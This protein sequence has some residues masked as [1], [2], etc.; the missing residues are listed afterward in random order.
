MSDQQCPKCHSIRTVKDQH[1]LKGICPSCGIAYDK[2]KKNKSQNQTEFRADNAPLTQ[3]DKPLHRLKNTLLFVPE[4]ID[5]LV[6][7]SRVIIYFIFF[8]WGWKFILSGSGWQAIMGSFM[9]NINLPFHEFG[10]VLF[11]PFG[12]FMTLYP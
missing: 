7:R 2:W 8:I 6:F 5:M 4:K 3:A 1:I 10:H 9:H 12:R 11:M